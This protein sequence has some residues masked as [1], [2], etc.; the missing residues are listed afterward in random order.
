MHCQELPC[1]SIQVINFIFITVCHTSTTLEKWCNPGV[2]SHGHITAVRGV[3]LFFFFFFEILYRQRNKQKQYILQYKITTT[4]QQAGTML[5]YFRTPHFHPSY[6]LPPPVPLPSHN[7]RTRK[8]NYVRGA[9]FLESEVYFMAFSI[10]YL[11]IILSTKSWR[12]IGLLCSL[13]V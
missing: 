5:R 3:L 9:K 11:I 10:L 1:F 2:D 4:K 8:R 6:L 7:K 13:L 12:R